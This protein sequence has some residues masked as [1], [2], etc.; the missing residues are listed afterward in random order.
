[1][2]PD[3]RRYLGLTF[4]HARRGLGCTSPNPLVGAILVKDDV[5]I[6]AG[7]HARAGTD[8]AE[9]RALQEAGPRARGS[10]LYVNIEPCCRHRIL[11]GRTSPCV[12]QIIEAGVKRVVAAAKDPNPHMNGRSLERLRQTGIVIEEE[13]PFFARLA[14]RT[15]EV[16]FT[17]V[18][19]GIP[20]VTLKAG[21]T[22]DGMIALASGESRWVTSSE[23]RAEGRRLRRLNDAVL[24]GIGTALTD[25]PGLLP[26]P[27][28]E[29][30][31]ARK[32]LRVVLDS[33]L[34]LSPG[35]RLASTA[36]DVPVLVYTSDEAP[37]DRRRALEARGITVS[38]AGPGRVSIP[39]V[40]EDL[41]S[42]GVTSVLVE[43]G[44]QVLGV[45]LRE[46]LADKIVLFVAPRVMGGSDSRSA[47]GG[48]G[49]G[50]LEEAARL[51]DVE[52]RASG[53]GFVITGYP[54]R[55]PRAGND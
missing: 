5:I 55:Q 21:M 41:A 33:S 36:K 1:M 12:D 40:L 48:P 44:S 17:F 52:I 16:F 42:R 45:F 37:A 24:V 30:D 49:P 2:T 29:D 4:D 13:D 46:G 50:E 26:D 14:A 32:T 7:H 10:V 53:D 39:R 51:E 35:S 6:G 34:R 3:D 47:F 38:N 28:S 15:N 31:S 22:V 8:H 18:E 43:G 11:E 54:R 27:L 25:D 9:T 19:T 20:F 23:A